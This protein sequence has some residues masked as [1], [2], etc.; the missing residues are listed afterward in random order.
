MI[1]KTKKYKLEPGTYKKLALENIL[2]AWWWAFLVPLAMCAVYAFFPNQHWIYITAFVITVLYV[3]FWYLQ[4]SGVA[5]LEQFK[6]LFE[7]VEYHIDSRQVLIM[8]N[9]KQGMP[10]PWDKIESA[11]MG[12]DYILLIVTRA[13]LIHLPHKIFSTQNDVKFVESILKRKN[14]I[15]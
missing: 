2:K 8:M 6:M 12:K 9:S 7:K 14:F 3:L 11:K 5:Y 4:F 10:I 15:K 13:Q 1:V